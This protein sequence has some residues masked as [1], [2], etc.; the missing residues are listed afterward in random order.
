MSVTTEI[1]TD[2]SNQHTLTRVIILDRSSSGEMR[3][4]D[5]SRLVNTLTH[6]TSLKAVRKPVVSREQLGRIHC[7]SGVTP[8]ELVRVCKCQF[9]R[10]KPRARG[11]IHSYTLPNIRSPTGV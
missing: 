7:E 3:V 4:R 6:E 10:C 8:A 2:L 9:N 11:R 5:R 1:R